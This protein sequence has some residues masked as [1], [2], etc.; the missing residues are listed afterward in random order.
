MIW[1]IYNLDI[2][3]RSMESGPAPRGLIDKIKV[4]VTGH[5]GTWNDQLI[6]LQLA[7]LSAGV[8]M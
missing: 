4:E 1:L 5:R 7:H 8:E 3:F 6:K 2:L